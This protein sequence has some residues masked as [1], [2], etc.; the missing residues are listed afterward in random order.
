MRS[1]LKYAAITVMLLLL[2]ACFLACAEDTSVPGAGRWK[3]EYGKYV[4]ETEKVTDER[5]SLTLK[6]DGTG[7]FDRDGAS[8]D[9]TWS[10]DGE[11]FTMTETYLGI[12]IEYVGTL[13]GDTL[14]IFNDDPTDEY[15][16]EYVF[17]R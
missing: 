3:G 16:Y 9:L 12:S 1:T 14:D 4:G 6:S 5:F 17:H 11:E 2:S 8:F 7:R 15:T 13:K 10:L